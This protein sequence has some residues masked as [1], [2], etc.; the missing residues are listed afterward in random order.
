[1][2]TEAKIEKKIVAYC[3][4]RRLYTRKFSSPAHRGV[5]DRI[6]CGRG[7][8]VFL[9]IKRP[10]NEPTRIQLYELKLLREAGMTAQWVD[11][12]E[13]AKGLIDFHFLLTNPR[14]LI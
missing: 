10:G 8:V 1:M 14:D 7:R 13:G 5:P 9:E 2:L 11:S 4:E 12:F 6:I 3:R